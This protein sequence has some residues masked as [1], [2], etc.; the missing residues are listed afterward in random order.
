MEGRRL[1]LAWGLA[2]GWSRVVDSWWGT[3][4]GFV[5]VGCGP[6]REEL[7]EELC[8]AELILRAEYGKTDGNSCLEYGNRENGREMP[9]P[10]SVPVTAEISRFFPVPVFFGRNGTRSVNT[11]FGAGRDGIF[12]SRF[13][14]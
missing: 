1:R 5:G 6:G 2:A 12:P 7:R 13:Q 14:P 11:G 10:V 3:G 8:W 9:S 4:E